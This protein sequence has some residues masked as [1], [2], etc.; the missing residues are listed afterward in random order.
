[1][2]LFLVNFK[3]AGRLNPVE[4]IALLM[5][6]AVHDFN[7]PG[8]NNGHEVKM[9]SELAL[10]HSDQSV[11]ERHHIASAFSVMHA[12][13]CDMLASLTNEQ[14]RKARALMIELVFHTDLSRHFD[15]VASLTPLAAKGHAV[16][17]A[18][19]S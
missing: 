14:F 4:L 17:I 9:V 2:H 12:R 1:M 11:L 5:A 6:A 7:H 18:K 16:L 19:H 13:G 15:F 8:T 10:L 3:L